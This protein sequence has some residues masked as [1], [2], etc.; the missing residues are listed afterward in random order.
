[1]RTGTVS[2]LARVAGCLVAL[3]LAPVLAKDNVPVDLNTATVKEL[4]ELPG[5]G[6]A[7]AKKIVA[8][9]PYAS[10]DDLAKAGVSKS[11]IDKLRSS[12]TVSGAAPSRTSSK[13]SSA[14]ASSAAP[15][16][17]AA[18]SG[19][20][21]LNTA[22]EKELEELPGVG[23][24][25][26]QKIIAG[27][28][29]AS[30]DDLAKVGVSKSTID[31]LR[32]SATVSGAA[33]SRASSKTS[34]AS[35]AA[36]SA[37]TKSAATSG[38]VDLN[39]ASEKELE[40]LPGVGAATAKKIV[41]GRPYASVDDLAK[42]GVSKSTIDKLRSSATVSAAAV[43][44]SPSAGS[45]APTAPASAPPVASKPPPSAAPATSTA[46]SAPTS[47]AHPSSTKPKLAPG[48]TININTAS[49]EELE[50]LPEIGP[51]KAQAIIDGRPFA[52]PE[53][54]MKVKGIKE[55]TF[56]KVKDH[57]VVR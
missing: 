7:T 21:D 55:K 1:M 49:L 29:Y 3:W 56:A 11:T 23:A 53:D 42:A 40:E 34:S 44:R 48:E 12:A 27:R 36:P 38:A 35:T 26:A 4:E 32:S 15:A 2:K 6:E 39:T 5:V 41:A 28:P 57:I 51:T 16:K 19:P 13:A 22:S 47:P 43:S 25:T 37:P 14:A 24:A 10:V 50:R 52:A 18:P 33:P 20:V 45:A 17:S 31:K 8:G 9:R 30:V 46:S 54:I